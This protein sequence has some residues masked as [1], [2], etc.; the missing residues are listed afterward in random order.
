MTIAFVDHRFHLSKDFC[1][2]LRQRE[3]PWGFSTFSE[4]VYMRTYSRSVGGKQ[5]QWADTIIRVVEGVL[6]I[7]L[8]WY[9]KMHVHWDERYWDEFAK[10]LATNMFEMKV[11]PPG[12][13]LFAMGTDYVYERG[14]SSLYNCGYVDINNDLA[15]ACAWIMDMLMLGVG[16]GASTQNASFKKPVIVKIDPS[17]YV[18]PDSREGWV[19]S[20][21]LLIDSYYNLTPIEFDY[22]KIRAKGEPVRGFG[23]V[24]SGPDPLILLHQRINTYMVAAARRNW[25]RSARTRLIADV[26][27][28]IGACIVSGNIRR[29]AE[30][31]TGSID[32]DSFLKLKDYKLN[33]ERAEIGWMSNNSVLLAESEQFEKIPLIAKGIKQNGEPGLINL[34]NIQKYGRTGK[35]M[36]DAAIGMNPCGEIA[37]QSFEVCNLAE[38]FPTRCNS[39][40]EFWRAAELATFY[41]S[42]VSLLPTHSE[43]T[44]SVVMRN[45]RVGTSVSGIADW[46][47]STNLSKVT[48]AL[49]RG[50]E[51][52]VEPM[53]RKL[54]AEAGV[55]A[56]IRLTTVKPS[57][58]ISLLA[59]VSPGMH[60]PVA[61]YAIRRIRIS[62]SS[63]LIEVLEK[64]GINGEPDSYSDNTLV[65]SFPIES[66]NGKTRSVSEVSVWEQASMV[67]MLQR[68]WADN[69]VS[70]TL[71]FRKNEVNQVEKVLAAF[72]PSIKSISMLPDQDE[73]MDSGE[74][75]A[76]LPYETI[77][78]EQYKEMVGSMK[79]INW[80]RFEGSDG[81]DSRFCDT[82]IC[83]V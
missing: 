77:S 22:S 79:S 78:K 25:D 12:R 19:E 70:N 75:Y 56:S 26:V 2:E 62:D 40:K 54:A 4:V 46:L 13:G 64:A 15:D 39:I 59:G 35:R 67:A 66:G 53:N 6:S 58:T 11:L 73:M 60:W 82:E 72:A 21:R 14:S 33:P 47:D 30:L 38:A 23:G 8:D 24:A 80:K 16:I 44:N 32:D 81:I 42:T 61:R 71:T 49:R 5:E 20:V 18:I 65:Y 27:N 45:H 69:A 76:Q 74:S 50:Y 51:E 34:I 63:P 10:E 57:G 29:S 17:Q 41:N 68:E 48:M 1:T 28:A 83:E 37:L 36:D 43:Q 31:L 7:R 55:P 52:Y 9:K 3:V